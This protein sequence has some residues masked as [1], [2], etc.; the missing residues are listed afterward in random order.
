MVSENTKGKYKALHRTA[1]PLRSIS[2]GE[3]GA[4]VSGT[5]DMILPFLSAY[6]C[7]DREWI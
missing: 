4:V 1:I 6:I 3:L 7:A 5:Y 2:A